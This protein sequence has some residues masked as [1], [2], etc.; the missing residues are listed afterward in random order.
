MAALGNGNHL[1][2][3]SQPR[4]I[5]PKF[6]CSYAHDIAC[7]ADFVVEAKSDKSALRQIRKVLRE[8]KFKNVDATPAWEN[9]T[10]HERVFVQGVATKHSPETTLEQLIDQEHLFSTH[11]RRCVRCNR[12]AEDNAVEGTPCPP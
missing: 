11:T 7:F 2:P 1:M 9:R 3:C 4:I 5:M 10:T 6:V 12:H 8:G